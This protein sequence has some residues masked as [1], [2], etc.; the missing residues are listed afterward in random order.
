MKKIDRTH[1]ERK[2]DKYSVEDWLDKD[3]W[4]SLIPLEIEDKVGK[5]KVCFQ[6]GNF[7]LTKQLDFTRGKDSQKLSICKNTKLEI[8]STFFVNKEH[9]LYIDATED[10][11]CLA[12]YINDSNE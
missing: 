3:N 11:N 12:R 9:K 4:E 2:S 6:D 8:T 7:T 5:E 1:L 10:E